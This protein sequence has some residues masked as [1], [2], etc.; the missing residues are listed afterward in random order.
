MKKKRTLLTILFVSFLC[1]QTIHADPYLSIFTKLNV[2]KTEHFEIFYP[3]ES[4]NSAYA[5]ANVVEELNA[6]ARE[7]FNSQEEVYLPV[8]I[9]PGSQVLNAA[10]IP[11]PFRHIVIYD[12]LPDSA[13]LINYK[14]TVV[15]IFYHELIHAVSYSVNRSKDIKKMADIMLDSLSAQL[16]QMPMGFNEGATVSFESMDGFGRLNNGETLNYILQAKMENKFPGPY[17]IQGSRDVFPSGPYPYYFGGAFAKYLQ[18]KYGLKQYDLLWMNEEYLSFQKIF[19][20]VFKKDLFDEWEEFKNSIPVPEL[21]NENSVEKII[22]KTGRYRCLAKR[23]YFSDGIEKEGAAFYSG[24]NCVYYFEAESLSS[25]QGK[26]VRKLFTADSTVSELEFSADGKNLLVTSLYP[27]NTETY[28]TRTFDME[29]K[30]FTGK[31]IKNFSYPVEFSFE[32]KNYLAGI[33]INVSDSSIVIYDEENIS[34]QKEIPLKHFCEVYKMCSTENGFAFFYREEGKWNICIAE[35][36][37]S[38]ENILLRTY[39]LPEKIIPLSISY[40]GKEKKSDSKEFV[41]S[42]TGKSF[43]SEDKNLPGATIRIAKVN[44]K[45]EEATIVFQKTDVSGGTHSAIKIA[46]TYAFVSR[47]SEWY[48]VSHFSKEVEEVPGGFSKEYKLE[49]NNLLLEV[50]EEQIKIKLNENLHVEKQ[51]EFGKFRRGFFIP[52]IAMNIIPSVYKE[53]LIDTDETQF[54]LGVTYASGFPEENFTYQLA[55]GYDFINNEIF[56][57]G[58]FVAGSE[59]LMFSALGGVKFEL[60][61]FKELYAKTSWF[62]SSPVLNNNFSLTVLFNSN[63]YYKNNKITTFTNNSQIGLSYKIKTGE[64]TFNYFSINNSL[65]WSNIM[66]FLNNELYEPCVENEKSY[67]G[68]FGLFTQI[69]IPR[70]IPIDNAF[71]YTYNLPLLIE[72]ELIPSS[73]DFF[74]AGAQAVLFA[75]ELQFQTG[76]F[77][78]YLRRMYFTGTY[79][80]DWKENLKPMSICNLPELFGNMNEM[81]LKA[82]VGL[83]AHLFCSPIIFVASQSNIDLGIDIVYYFINEQNSKNYLIKLFGNIKI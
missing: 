39:S 68:N 11:Y 47:K 61:D 31:K 27:D 66:K 45:K 6:K 54:G 23:K 49:N 41:I 22:S 28:Y 74:S 70:L 24:D 80:V 7:R 4:Q 44:V 60:L 18:E 56:A 76:K 13:E 43:E 14:E 58:A 5:I 30:K 48:E 32:N 73:T 53:N 8:T 62:T 82:G 79:V 29:K 19:K 64:G 50:N 83:G 59:K 72:V 17:E 16:I 9:I 52:Y 35:V 10:F 46:D 26:K 36:E 34:I 33:R 55:S 3:E 40:E 2:I 51:N 12:T 21:A 77:P 63:Y 38:L 81:K 65:L 15:E 78:A 67:I 25:S 20:S 57:S 42:V 1:L 71:G 37:T 75:K 69:H